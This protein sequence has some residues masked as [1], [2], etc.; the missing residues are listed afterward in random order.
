MLISIFRNYD[1]KT[2][3]ILALFSLFIVVFSLSFHE[4]SHAMTAY[5][6]GDPTAKYNGRLTLNPFKHLHPIGFVCMLLFGFG[7]ANPVPINANY[8]KNR[9]GGMAVSALAGPVSNI[10]LSFI[11]LLMQNILQHIALGMAYA[12][13][14]KWETIISI[15]LLFFGLAH[16][17]NLYL[18]V[19]NLLPIPPLDGS[20]ILFIF[21]PADKYFKVMKYEQFIALGLI[22]LLYIG[23]L[24]G[25][26]S[27][28]TAGISNGMQALINLFM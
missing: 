4:F 7:W 18:A 14:L 27:F 3:I 22:V 24:N 6:L 28:I 20:R 2:A 9:K 16:T 10:L 1:F 17:M 12:A 15:L 11:S 19:F 23:V 21:L 8:F 26:L 13:F 25:P 5:A